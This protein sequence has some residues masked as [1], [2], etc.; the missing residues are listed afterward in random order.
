MK[1]V[2]FLCIRNTARSQMA[3]GWF[4]HLYRGRAR[5]VSGGVKAGDGASNRQVGR[6]SQ[7]EVR[8]AGGVDP[9][10]VRVMAEAGVDISRQRPKPFTGPMLRSAD[11]VV[12]VCAE[13]DRACPVLPVEA[14]HWEV[15]NPHGRPVEVFRRVR[16][17]IRRRVEGMEREFPKMFAQK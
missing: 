8:G 7:S 16:D 5:A 14:V 6:R 2:L 3:E 10:A 15:E 9:L 13:F 17:E 1:T 11:L 12:K 4:N